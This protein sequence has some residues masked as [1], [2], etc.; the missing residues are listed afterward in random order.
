MIRIIW[1]GRFQHNRAAPRIDDAGN[2]GQPRTIEFDVRRAPLG[3]GR[4]ARNEDGICQIGYIDCYHAIAGWDPHDVAALCG[5]F[6]TNKLKNVVGNIRIAHC[7]EVRH[8]E[9][10]LSYESRCGDFHNAERKLV[11]SGVAG[12]YVQVVAAARHSHHALPGKC[13]L[14]VNLTTLH[15]QVKDLATHAD[16]N[17]S[18]IQLHGGNGVCH[19]LLKLSEQ[20]RSRGVRDIDQTNTT[21]WSRG[22]DDLP[23]HIQ[24]QVI[25]RAR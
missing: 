18:V 10:S 16:V 8:G 2:H 17:E 25:D 15:V 11:R 22:S 19:F 13:E 24:R 9:H 21:A 4:R 3:D 1:I 5:S 7:R 14:A 20:D 23:V 12:C 6:N